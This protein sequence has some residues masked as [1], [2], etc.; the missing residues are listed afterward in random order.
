M[1]EETQ[2]DKA[3]SLIFNNKVNA[4]NAFE[5]ETGFMKD[6][7]SIFRA[8]GRRKVQS[9]AESSYDAA[10][11]SAVDMD[12]EL[13]G[14]MSEMGWL[15]ASAKIYGYRVDYVHQETY[16]ILGGL[17]RNMTQPPDD[18]QTSFDQSQ[19]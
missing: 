17:H 7:T 16:R 14:I 2:L 9:R 18:S 11:T 13:A 15:K 1:T 10:A 4:K 3:V 5:V 19:T 8:T 12:E 6:F